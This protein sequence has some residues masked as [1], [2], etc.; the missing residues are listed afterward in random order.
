MFD[1]SEERNCILT[2]AKLF[3]EFSRLTT[4]HQKSIAKLIKLIAES[5]C[6]AET[7][8]Q[9][10]EVVFDALSPSLLLSD[11]CTLS[12][13]ERN[14]SAASSVIAKFDHQEKTFAERLKLL[15]EEK[16]VPQIELADRIGVHQSAISMM[17]SRNCRPQTKTVKKIAMALDVEPHE[18]WP[19]LE[20][21]T[22]H[23][24]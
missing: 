24:G 17:I 19:A 22:G 16:R 8:E 3:C 11:A 6:D 9:A 18:L 21:S 15:M 20:P 5:D 10:I 7:R 1:Q 13:G 14:T 23:P 4:N 12:S 2:F